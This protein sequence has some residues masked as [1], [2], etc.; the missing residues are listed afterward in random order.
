MDMIRIAKTDIW[1]ATI[2]TTSDHRIWYTFKPVRVA[3]PDAAPITQPD[4]FNPHRFIPPVPQEHPASAAD[5]QLQPPYMSS[6]IV[7]L[8]GMPTSPWV[9]PQA[10]VA[11]GRVED[12]MYES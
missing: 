6:S 9:D 7:V 1:Y 10:E 5:R 8:P 3:A 4:P 12:R 11:K 2:T